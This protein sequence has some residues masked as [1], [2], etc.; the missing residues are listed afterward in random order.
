MADEEEKEEENK[1]EETQEDKP[2]GGGKKL[3]I[4]GLVAGLMVGGG[5]AAGYFIMMPSPEAEIEHVEEVVVEEIVPELPDYQ[6]ARMDRLQLP[7]FYKGRILNYSVMDV[8][9]ETI[10]ATDKML[11]VKNILIIRDA[12]LRFYSV[13]S[14]GRED[15]PNIVDFDKL[16][17]KI[18]EF[19]NQEAHKD[20][21]K[22][23]VISESRSY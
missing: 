4:I 23:V 21:V 2:K 9:L 15:N 10:G 7:L 19:A 17:A 6:Y 8:S 13:N 18:L 14:V 5:A 20:V 11:V 1:E 22:R 3:L 16:S 12:L